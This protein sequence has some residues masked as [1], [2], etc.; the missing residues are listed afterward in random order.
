MS[1]LD[2]LLDRLRRAYA[3]IAEIEQAALRVPGDS[4]LLANLASLKSDAEDLEA[5]WR[6]LA[7]NE[8]KEVCRYRLIPTGM[9][10]YA[11]Q[12]VTRSLLEF[13]E[14]FSQIYDSLAHGPKKRM[15]LTD[16]LIAETRFDFGF[17][18]PGSLGIVLMVQGEPSF[19][20][21]K[22]DQSIDALM[23]IAG[24]KDEDSVREMSRTLGGAVVKRAF[25]WSR[26]N[27]SAGYTVDIG[28]TT[29][30][31]YSRGGTIDVTTFGRVVEI[32]SK[33][34]DTERDTIRVPGVLIGIDAK[35]KRF[36]FVAYD[37]NG[38]PYSGF[39][40]EIFPVKQVWSIN[41]SYTAQIT[42][43]TVIEYATQTVRE[44]YRLDM[45]EPILSA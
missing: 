36:R 6:Q 43:E 15:R 30:K 2:Y 9:M 34:S 38:P 23:Q 31:G 28:W 17:S 16:D 13:Q 40:S 44:S 20:G 12:Y 7:I 33:T 29:T 14:L 10:G 18:Y 42:V 39:L 26:V 4:F 25:D 24:V 35:A 3:S 41:T 22:Y 27:L 8:Q 19:F 1:G 32:I 5:Q 11:I 45:L 37:G 21:D